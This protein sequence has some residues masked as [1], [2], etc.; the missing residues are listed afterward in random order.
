[1]KVLSRSFFIFFCLVLPAAVQA[2]G[3]AD[4]TRDMTEK[5]GFYDFF[6]DE[7]KG[8]VYLKL[9]RLGEE[10][11]FQTGLP[12]GLGSNDIGLD[13]RQLGVTRLVKFERAGDKILLTEVN[14]KFRAS[15]DNPAEVKAVEEAFATSVLWGFKIEATDKT[16]GLIDLTD[17]LLSDQHGIADRID[18]TRQ[19]NFSI[20]NS[21]S[22]LYPARTKSFPLNTEFESTL[23]FRGAKPGQYVKDVSPDGQQFTLRQHISFVKLPDD[24]YQTRAFH[25]NSG[26]FPLAYR[27]YAV[28]LGEDLTQ[29]LIPRHRLIKK[30]P[31]QAVSDPVEPIIYYL[32]AGTPEPIRSALMEGASWWAQAFEAAGFSNAFRVEILPE[33]AD[34]MDVRYNIIN[35]TH[36][37][38]R[39]WSYGWGVIDP[40]TGEILKGHVTLGSLRVRQDIL[41]ATALIAPYED[42]GSDINVQKDMALARIRQLAAH[43]VGHTLGIAHNFAAS[44]SNRASVMDYPHP[45]IKIAGDGELDLSEA[46]DTDIGEWDKL[47]VRY[48][49]S[50]FVSPEA[51]QAGLREILKE[52]ESQGLLFVTD[53]DSRSL[54]DFNAGSSLWDN[55]ANAIA[56]LAHLREVRRIALNNFSEKNIPVG[57]PWSS[58]E[59]VLVPLYYLPRYQLEAAGKYVGG[60]F[61]EY[62]LRGEGSGIPYRI[63]PPEQQRQAL[64]E[65]LTTLTAGYLVLPE[66]I[67]RLIPPKAYGYDLSRESFP[68]K[69]RG[70]FDAL[71]IGEAAADHVFSILLDPARLARLEQFHQRGQGMMSL[72]EYFDHI[73]AATVRADRQ[74]KLGGAMERRVGH[75]MIL[76]TMQLAA[77]KSAAESVRAMA[78]LKLAD[79][80]DWMENGARKLGKHPAFKAHYAFEAARIR[81]FMD[82]TFDPASETPAVLPPGSPI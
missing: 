30:N 33:D 11:I 36:R 21:R 29:R 2:A 70:Q 9:D 19:G 15:S 65:I 27:D 80:A 67:L 41:I 52:R 42:A 46:Y 16:A 51:E 71:T 5:K 13:R 12:Q 40:R 28:P 78:R 50:Q 81:A 63:V 61:Y 24:G 1:M 14:T 23:T 49:Y 62:A 32:D 66:N 74:E 39:G 38:T 22:A 56:E 76:K 43:E 54:S 47:V 72:D 48:G 59:E 45:Q 10:F 64:D 35:W 26:M 53:E 55:G 58:L 60:L 68:R 7:D 20:D 17:F 6:L 57:E 44:L 77:D 31:D 79:L 75:V 34:P 25:P 82:G 37:A 18:Q 3:L 73:L 4:F 8:R 69:T